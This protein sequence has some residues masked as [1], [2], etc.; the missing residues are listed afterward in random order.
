MS[1]FLFAPLLAVLVGCSNEA[2]AEGSP[3][4]FSE[5]V[6]VMHDVRDTSVNNYYKEI[7]ES[8]EF[9]NWRFNRDNP[10]TTKIIGSAM[11][12]PRTLKIQGEIY[13]ELDLTSYAFASKLMSTIPT[14][15]VCTFRFSAEK[16]GLKIFNSATEEFLDFRT[17]AGRRYFKTILDA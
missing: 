12:S 2:P 7:T 14:T 10:D 3:E 4:N 15:H 5:S 1:K 6:F 16:V 8:P 17:E 9:V 13:F 11:F